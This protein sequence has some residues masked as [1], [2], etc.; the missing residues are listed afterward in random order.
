MIPDDP[1]VDETAQVEPLGSEVRHCRC[2]F[3]RD[4]VLETQVEVAPIDT[5]R[6]CTGTRKFDT[7]AEMD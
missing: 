3:E 1:D 4:G 6:W 5:I 7:N 2:C